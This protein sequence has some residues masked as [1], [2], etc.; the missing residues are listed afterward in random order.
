LAAFDRRVFN[1]TSKGQGS[2][3]EGGAFQ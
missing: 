1:W 2:V 3:F